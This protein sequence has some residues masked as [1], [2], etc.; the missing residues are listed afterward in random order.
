M[1]KKFK[2]RLNGLLIL[3]TIIPITCFIL[4]FSTKYFTINISSTKQIFADDMSLFETEFDDSLSYYEKLIME[5][6]KFVSNDELLLND[7]TKKE[8]LDK[9]LYSI[10]GLDEYFYIVNEDNVVSSVNNL[11]SLKR[12]TSVLIKSSKNVGNGVIQLSNLNDN[13]LYF[14][15]GY[16]SENGGD[17]ML[18]FEVNKDIL[19]KDLRNIF[20]EKLFSFKIL[21]DNEEVISH[22]YYD[23]NKLEYDNVISLISTNDAKFF[24]AKNKLAADDFE[25]ILFKNISPEISFMKNEAIS[26]FTLLFIYLIL[27]LVV[28]IK[29]SKKLINP[30]DLLLNLVEAAAESKS[31]K[32][33]IDTVEYEYKEIFVLFDQ[34]LQSTYD[35]IRE[36][37]NQS[38]S[39]NEKNQIMEELNNQLKGS[40]DHIEISTKKLQYIERQSKALVDNI[41]D[42][43]WVIDHK[44]RIIFINKVVEDKLGYNADELIGVKLDNLLKRCISNEDAFQEMFYDDFTDID[45]VFVKKNYET[46]EIYSS[47][48]KRIFV[49]NKLVQIQGVCRDITE[50]RFIEEQMLQKK[51]ISNTLN[52]ISEILTRPEKL[53][54]LLDQIVVRIERLLNPLDCTI[55]LI[56]DKG[57]LELK[58][59]IGECYTLSQ[60]KYLD[61]NEDISGK[62]IIDKKIIIISEKQEEYDV[63]YSVVDKAREL[64]LL[65]LEYDGTI[66]GV[67]SIGLNE[68]ISDVNIK[69]LQVFTNQASAAIEKAKIYS[70]LK[71]NYLNIIKALVL[72]VEAKDAYTE[73]HS[74]RVSKYSKMI[75]EELGLSEEEVS[76]ID[77]AG[78]LHDIGKIGISDLTLTKTG[79]LTEEEFNDIKNHPVNGGRIVSDMKLHPY[80]IDGVL[81]HHKRFDLKGYPEYEIDELP[82]A[83]RIIA[84]AD[85]FDAMTS[86]RSYQFAKSNEEALLELESNAGTQFCP[87][88]VKVMKIVI[89]KNK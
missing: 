6:L 89:R 60:E 71:K 44:G 32:I 21:Y 48:T 34:M 77:V 51:E 36:I 9:L 3:G 85:A 17:G 65:P 73:N 59:G 42:L 75:A 16:P 43:M 20:D 37:E 57:R 64:I 63:L 2:N 69:V 49:N 50:E 10:E 22:N 54:V 52:E 33:D 58:A 45:L 80:I 13:K 78:L 7:H 62:A 1:K 8:Y 84:V 5:S 26:F 61:V 46:E 79:E 88:I 67:M 14:V 81:L 28:M 35:N 40:L 56:D 87:E 76:Y 39:I 68:K 29:T 41:N 4:M 23:E 31:S 74:I 38:Q 83:A 11:K 70:E 27:L 24:A 18:V 25:Y 47:R 53:E 86:N 66:L 72:T 55:R 30:I 19:L 82:I 15:Y 12:E